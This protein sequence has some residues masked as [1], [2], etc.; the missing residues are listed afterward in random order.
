VRDVVSEME[1]EDGVIWVYGI[2]EGSVPRHSQ[3]SE[4][5]T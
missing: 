3:T 5:K 1:I 4:S 2:G